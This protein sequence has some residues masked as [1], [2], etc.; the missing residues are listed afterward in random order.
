MPKNAIIIIQT[1]KFITNQYNSS[2]SN[3]RS[4]PLHF[5]LT[6]LLRFLDL[7]AQLAQTTRKQF[8]QI[9]SRFPF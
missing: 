9:R 7:L 2:S 3:S 6:H 4:L 8:T 5:L 1:H